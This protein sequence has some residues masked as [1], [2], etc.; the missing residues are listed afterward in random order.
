MQTMLII[1]NYTG[2]LDLYVAAGGFHPKRVLPVVLDIGTSNQALLDDPRW[3]LCVCTCVCVCI[4]ICPCWTT[5]GMY[6]CLCLCPP[7]CSWYWNQ[8]P[9]SVKRDPRCFENV[10]F[11][12]EKLEFRQKL[13]LILHYWLEYLNLGQINCWDQALI[14]F[15]NHDVCYHR[16]LGRREARLEGEDY[17][18]FIGDK[19]PNN[20]QTRW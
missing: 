4:C 5:Q 14:S 17:Y 11:I 7:C 19:L 20:S 8:K 9:G 12:I 15:R 2:K 3:C 16:Y 13:S 10:L 18:N 1:W 6:T